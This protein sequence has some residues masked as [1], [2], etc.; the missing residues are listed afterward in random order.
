LSGYIGGEGLK[1]VL[2]ASYDKQTRNILNRLRLEINN[3][4]ERYDGFTLL[5]ENLDVFVSLSPIKPDYSIFIENQDQFNGT[6]TILES[7]NKILETIDFGNE[8]EYQT[9]VGSS[10]SIDLTQFRKLR[11]FEKLVLLAG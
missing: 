11:E 9:I 1:I 2:L 8:E 3:K 5:L 10:G 7:K 6:I 4:F